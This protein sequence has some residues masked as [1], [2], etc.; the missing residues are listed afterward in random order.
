MALVEC[1]HITTIEFKCIYKNRIGVVFYN[2]RNSLSEYNELLKQSG[3]NINNLEWPKIIKIADY[4]L[5]MFIFRI[6]QA[7]K[8]DLIALDNAINNYNGEARRLCDFMLELNNINE[9]S[10][11]L[12]G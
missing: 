2:T 12:L 5:I 7:F 6:G 11:E 10:M 4:N 3:I 8:R 1:R 9:T